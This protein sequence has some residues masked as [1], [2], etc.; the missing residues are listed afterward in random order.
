MIRVL[1]P[2][3]LML[4]AGGSCSSR[5]CREMGE[6]GKD[7]VDFFRGIIDGINDGL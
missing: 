3:E 6:L 5:R 1:G 2:H 4:V 7:I